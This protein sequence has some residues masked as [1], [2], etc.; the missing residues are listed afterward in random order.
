MMKIWPLFLLLSG[1]ASAPVEVSK[2]D[3]LLKSYELAPESRWLSSPSTQE[4]KQLLRT[5]A[6]S[7][8]APGMVGLLDVERPDYIR[9]EATPNGYLHCR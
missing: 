5:T 8:C 1:C 7:L 6:Q 4:A 9:V 2:L 3:L